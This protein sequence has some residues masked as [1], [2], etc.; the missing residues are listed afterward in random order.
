MASHDSLQADQQCFM[1]DAQEVVRARKRLNG[2]R[3]KMLTPVIFKNTIFPNPDDL[4][5][6]SMSV[7]AAQTSKVHH[8]SFG[9]RKI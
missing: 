7:K 4:K 3:S 6:R 1:K 8:S 5:N 9:S 2:N